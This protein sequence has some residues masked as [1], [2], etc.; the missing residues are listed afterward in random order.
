MGKPWAV[1]SLL[2]ATVACGG[3]RRNA[4]DTSTLLRE[5]LDLG[6]RVGQGPP[7]PADRDVST[8]CVSPVLSWMAPMPQGGGHAD[9]KER[10]AMGRAGFGL[11]GERAH[12]GRVREQARH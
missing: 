4:D 9:A 11:G 3:P 6:A 1:C 8:P 10:S 5:L 12:G 7:A 2:L